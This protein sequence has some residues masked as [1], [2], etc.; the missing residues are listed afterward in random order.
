MWDLY[1]HLPGST[2]SPRI[3]QCSLGPVSHHLDYPYPSSSDSKRL[4]DLLSAQPL[5][6]NSGRDRAFKLLVTFDY[7]IDLLYNQQL[8]GAHDRHLHESAEGLPHPHLRRP[9]LLAVRLQP[10]RGLKA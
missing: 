7:G 9:R 2:I 5:S 6:Y 8:A 10:S 3:L 1:E 4:K